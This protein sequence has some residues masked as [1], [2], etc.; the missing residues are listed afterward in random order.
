M[1]TSRTLDLCLIKPQC[2]FVLVNRNGG[3]HRK[4]AEI[5]SKLVFDATGKYI[6]PTRYNC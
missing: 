4:L 6:Y 2:D 3:Q 1:A 5:M